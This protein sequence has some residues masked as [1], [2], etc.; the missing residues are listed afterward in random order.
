MRSDEKLELERLMMNEAT[1]GYRYSEDYYQRAA[2]PT[3][4]ILTQ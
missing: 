1:P 4:P 2:T 3:A